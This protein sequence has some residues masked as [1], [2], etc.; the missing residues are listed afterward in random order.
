V[1]LCPT[2][3]LG[4]DVFKVKCGH[5]QVHDLHGVRASVPD[6]AIFVEKK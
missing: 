2:Q 6:F 1:K 3:V 5:R 4:M